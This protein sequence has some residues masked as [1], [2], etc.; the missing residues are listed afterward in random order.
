VVFAYHRIQYFIQPI[1]H[2]VGDN[3]GIKRIT[4]NEFRRRHQDLFSMNASFKRSKKNP[5]RENPR[6][7]PGL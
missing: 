5:K 1:L 6:L 2:Q 3:I 7:L 4:Q